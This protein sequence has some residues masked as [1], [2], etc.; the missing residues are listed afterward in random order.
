MQSATGV[1]PVVLRARLLHP[2]VSLFLLRPQLLTRLSC[3]PR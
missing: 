3:A 1:L 2:M